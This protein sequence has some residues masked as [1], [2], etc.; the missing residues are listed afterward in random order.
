VYLGP[1]KPFEPV[2]VLSVNS[3]AENAEDNSTRSGRSLAALVLF[4][5]LLF[6]T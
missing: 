6:P 2:A 1:R 3:P 4:F 5:L